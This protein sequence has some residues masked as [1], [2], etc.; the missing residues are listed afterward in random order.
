MISSRPA[1]LHLPSPSREKRREN[2]RKSLKQS[3]N[4]AGCSY[5]SLTIDTPDGPVVH[6]PRGIVGWLD[7][8]LAD[9]CYLFD[10]NWNHGHRRWWWWSRSVILI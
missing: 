8:W 4:G 10:P 2:E 9:V 6:I 5:K 1:P 7:G 3:A